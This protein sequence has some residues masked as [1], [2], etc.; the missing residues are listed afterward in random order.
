M[1]IITTL[2]TKI[3]SLLANYVTSV[4]SNVASAIVPLA[5]TGATIY[6]C[7]IGYSIAT[8]ANEDSIYTALWKFF[9]I[10][11]VGGIAL[12]AGVY[13]SFFVE[14]INGMATGIVQIVSP[15]N[16]GSLGALLDQVSTPWGDLI[17]KL[18]EQA[19]SS[20]GLFPDIGLYLS[21]GVVAVAQ[22]LL[23]FVGVGL[24]LLA[25][26]SLQLTL[27]VGPIFVLCAMFPATQKYFESWLSQALSY[28]FTIGFITAIISMLFSFVSGMC[29]QISNNL[30]TGDIL[31]S[32]VSLC[33]VSGTIVVVMLNVPTIASAITGGAGVQGIG[34]AIAQAATRGRAGGNGSSSSNNS[35][36]SSG[37]EVS[38]SS[39]GGGSAG[40]SNNSSS[41]TGGQKPL[42]QRHT[43]QNI[44][45]RK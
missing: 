6:I 25:K 18:G 35:P 16:S 40:G 17:Q 14:A 42:Y 23:F 10:A 1:G 28:V 33:I 5:L 11:F 7:I 24:Y 13:Q 34:R 32:V 26:I 37:G 30:D 20:T 4:S 38:G 27:G 9:K 44:L 36:Q 45:K 39:S 8:G 15:S 21:A 2:E 31:T 3:D 41:S 22:F 29:E 19:Q 12:S 43:L